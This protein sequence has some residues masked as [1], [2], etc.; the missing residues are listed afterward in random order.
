MITVQL[1]LCND[2]S[3]AKPYMISQFLIYDFELFMFSI[4]LVKLI[5]LF[6]FT[7][8]DFEMVFFF[9]YLQLGSVNGDDTSKFDTPH[10]GR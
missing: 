3:F 8:L 1:P 9:F 2:Y 10:F 4:F 5:W 6:N 7:R